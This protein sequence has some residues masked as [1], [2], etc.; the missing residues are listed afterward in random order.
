MHMRSLC[1]N[2]A[3]THSAARNEHRRLQSSLGL[4]EQMQ[5]KEVI[6]SAV[7][8]EDAD[9]MTVGYDACEES[10]ETDLMQWPEAAKR[11]ARNRK[12]GVRVTCSWGDARL[13]TESC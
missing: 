12:V 7:T 9:S 1:G 10:I 5:N 13:R 11:E 8:A 6:L 4:S 2:T 3:G